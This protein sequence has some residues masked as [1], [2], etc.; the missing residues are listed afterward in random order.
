MRLASLRRCMCTSPPPPPPTGGRSGPLVLGGSVVLGALVAAPAFYHLRGVATRPVPPHAAGMRGVWASSGADGG[1]A[2]LKLNEV[3]MASWEDSTGRAA[4]GAARYDA[5]ALVVEPLFG[6]WL[7]GAPL[8]LP[9]A[10][11]PA[12]AAAAAGAGD[13]E[14]ERLVAD[15]REFTRGR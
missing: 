6:G 5:E 7:G 2:L 8:V 10:L 9:V 1:W 11:W 13:A 4:K 15:G 14:S 12:A 3:G